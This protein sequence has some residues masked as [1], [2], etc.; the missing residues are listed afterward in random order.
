M[1]CLVVVTVGG[2]VMPAVSAGAQRAGRGM[3][4][5]P[6]QTPPPPT[7]PAVAQPAVAQPGGSVAWRPEGRTVAGRSVVH[8]GNSG[9][10]EVAWLDPRFLRLA[11]VPGTG[12]PGGPWSG[13]GQVAPELQGILV[14]AFNGG[15]QTKDTR[16]GWYTD[17]RILKGLV[18][19]EASI[20][21]YRDGH[22]AVGE[23]ERD[24]NLTPDVVSVRQNLPLLVD[25][26]TPV[27]AADNPSAWGGSV[28]G[29][30]TARAGVGVDA[31]GGVVVA[32][33]RV[34]PRGLADALVAAGAGRAMQLDI[35]PD[36]VAF[37]LYDRN[38]DGSIR[39]TR[40]MGT[41]GPSSLYLTPYS[42]DFFAVYI[43]AVV[44]TGGTGTI[45]APPVN[46]SAKVRSA[47]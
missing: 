18:P 11:F 13:G 46:A 1:S 39:G 24:V 40:V 12:D 7:P 2:F 26:G 17:G 45:G 32:Q 47:K 36:W 14:A 41:G 30:A 4:A 20:V 15:F 22:I 5:L 23:W 21:I 25:G 34:S 43:K 37:V 16:G 35:N 8:R 38:P 9:G 10:V 19:G 31:N 29:V 3:T 33:A 6:A 28:A 27:P 44:A 42:R